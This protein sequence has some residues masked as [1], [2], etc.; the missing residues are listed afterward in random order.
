MRLEAESRR[1][2]TEDRRQLWISDWGLGIGEMARQGEGDPN[3]IVSV[4]IS[5]GREKRERE[6]LAADARRQK[7]T[8]ILPQRTLS[9]Q[10]G[11]IIIGHGER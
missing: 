1:Q 10:R 4:Q 3:E 11:N 9:A 8:N 2:R 7:R 5:W 6:E